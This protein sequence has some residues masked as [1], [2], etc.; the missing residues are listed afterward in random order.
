MK[1]QTSVPRSK[2]KSNTTTSPNWT[3][4]LETILTAEAVPKADKLL[5]LTIDIGIEKRTV[6]SGIAQHFKP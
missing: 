3:S 2:P 4:E 6:V 1:K 5:K